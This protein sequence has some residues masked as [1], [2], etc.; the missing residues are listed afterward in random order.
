M[1]KSIRTRFRAYQLGSEG[2]SSSYFTGDRL[3]LIQLG[4]HV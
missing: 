3:T 4:K 2:F 1:I